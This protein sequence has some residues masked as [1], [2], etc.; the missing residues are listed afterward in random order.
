MSLV[1]CR[2]SL[3]VVIVVVKFLL[4]ADAKIYVQMGSGNF[5]T[6]CSVVK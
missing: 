2:S 5:L 3:G 4:G 6:H 1:K